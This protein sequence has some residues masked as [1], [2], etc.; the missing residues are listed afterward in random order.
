VSVEYGKAPWRQT[1]DI[2]CLTKVGLPLKKALN[3]FMSAARVWTKWQGDYAC[4]SD[5]IDGRLQRRWTK[6]SSYVDDSEQQLDEMTAI[7]D[8][9]G[10]STPQRCAAA[11]ISA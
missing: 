8:T 11:S 1:D 7:S 3:Q 9:Q 10:L 5:S 2:T 4:S 6:T